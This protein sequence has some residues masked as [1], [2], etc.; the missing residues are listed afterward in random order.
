MVTNA[1][2]PIIPASPPNYIIAYSNTTG[3]RRIA[4]S[5]KF[6]SFTLYSVY[7][8]CFRSLPQAN[9]TVLIQGLKASTTLPNGAAAGGLISRQV[10]L[11]AI[12]VQAANQ[13]AQEEAK[14]MTKVDFDTSSWSGLNSVNF[15][16]NIE[17]QQA[18]MG[19][20]QLE[21]DLVGPACSGT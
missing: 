4:I 7:I 1:S 14:E 12:P 3:A 5:P 8:S 17:G 18:D 13:T 9:C 16:V 11:P 15:V 19:I 6:S 20:D 10:E 21:Y 2:S